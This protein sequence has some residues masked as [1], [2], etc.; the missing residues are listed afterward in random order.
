MADEIE[1][2][3]GFRGETPGPSTDAWARARSAI[4]AA[5]TEEVPAGRRRRSAPGR[6]RLGWASGVAVAV[7]VGAVLAVVMPG[8]PAARPPGAASARQAKETAYVISRAG[9]ALAASGQGNF[10]GY[11]R[12]VLPPG[13]RVE[14]V[15]GN[16][17]SGPGVHSQL[18]AS[19][20][21]SWSYHGT[22]RLA[23]FTPAGQRV[24]GESTT[25]AAGGGAT[26][27]V[28]VNYRDAT[29]WHATTAA[30]PAATAPPECG[31]GVQ[32][33]P[34]GWV[35]YIRHELRCGGYTT[36]GR[37]QVDGISAIKLTER[38]NRLALWVNPATYLPVRIVTEGRQRTQTDF[39]WLP[40]TPANLAQ[41]SMP[42]PAGFRQVRPPS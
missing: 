11:A 39:R 19:S 10:V 16:L 38:D 40:P 35:A 37:Q 41:L 33:G 1:L 32:I 5:K 24:L 31:I 20:M 13:S 28:V 18:N 9:R 34:G 8:S 6:H 3:R 25:I 42:V 7:A 14:P 26:T 23:T 15:A 30:P 22:G 27:V 2:L 4:A 17:Q 21:T 12:T 29:W 36:D